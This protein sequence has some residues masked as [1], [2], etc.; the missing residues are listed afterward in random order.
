MESYSEAR[1]KTSYL[2]RE[3]IYYAKCDAEKNRFGDVSWLS[4]LEVLSVYD[5]K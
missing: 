5:F 2:A 3:A 1:R 4:W